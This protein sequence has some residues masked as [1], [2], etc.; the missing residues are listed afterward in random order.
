MAYVIAIEFDPDELLDLLGMSS[1]DG[2]AVY[3]GLE[4]DV[5]ILNFGP[6]ES[7]E[8]APEK[9]LLKIGGGGDLQD[10]VMSAEF[11]VDSDPRRFSIFPMHSG[12]KL[13]N[14]LISGE[15]L[16]AQKETYNTLLNQIKTAF[17][18]NAPRVIDTLLGQSSL[19]K[20]DEKILNQLEQILD[21][22]SDLARIQN[23]LNENRLKNHPFLSDLREKILKGTRLSTRQRAAI[24]KFEGSGTVDQTLLNR[25]NAVLKKTPNNRFLKSLK[26]QV[27]SGRSL[28]PKQISAL[29]S[30][31][32]GKPKKQTM[33]ESKFGTL[34]HHDRIKVILE[35]LRVSTR[36]NLKNQHRKLIRELYN[37]GMRGTPINTSYSRG[38]LK[39]LREII[40][41]LIYGGGQGGNDFLESLTTAERKHWVEGTFLMY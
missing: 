36:P 13:E 5:S 10:D 26:S 15:K 25:I 9:H 2:P 21:P 39:V 31:E 14:F 1:P 29:E 41:Y 7:T 38:E 23:L 12:K 24:G 27:L 32:S 33:T 3:K 16:K 37:D 30:N 35:H 22:S 19:S 28:S 6:E 34:G 8:T 20:R 17:G 18:S 11:I 40:D 4:L